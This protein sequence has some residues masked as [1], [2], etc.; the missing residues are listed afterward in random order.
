[1]NLLTIPGLRYDEVMLPVY[2]P[3]PVTPARGEGSYLW[4]EAGREYIDFA[5]GI[6]TNGLGHCH[7]MLIRTLIEQSRKLWHV[8]NIFATRSALVLAEK[9]IANTFAEKV[10]FANSGAEAN[11]AALK[12]ARYFGIANFHSQKTKIVAFEKGFHGRTFFTVSVGGQSQYSD[13]FGPK[14]GDIVHV[15]F[16]D[17]KAAKA[18]IDDNTCAVILEPVQ[19]EG[20]LTPATP[21]F[22]EGLRACCDKVKALLIF[23]EVQCGMGRTGALYSYMHYNVVPDILTSA[24]ALGCGFPVSAM[25]TTDR[26]AK[27][28][29]P[30]LHGTTHGGNPLACAVACT[31]FDLLND[32]QL[33]AGVTEKRQIFIKRLESMQKQYNIFSRFVGKG[34]LLGAKLRTPYHSQATTIVKMA[35]QEGVIILKAGPDVLRFTPA[36]NIADKTIHLGMDRLERAIDTFCQ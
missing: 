7:P 32:A 4:D 27:V 22:L 26:V 20:G 1:M 31:A 24:K 35:A 14:P 11:E 2:N 28:M 6:A 10:F 33:L 5:A 9:M 23:D 21:A 30:G 8:G 12:L 13:G 18:V 25:L 19:G 16:N 17:L 34:L 15:P 3:L 36:L 29:K